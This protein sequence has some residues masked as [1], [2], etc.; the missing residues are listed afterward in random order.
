MVINLNTTG[1]K[2]QLKHYFTEGSGQ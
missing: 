1:K 2:Q